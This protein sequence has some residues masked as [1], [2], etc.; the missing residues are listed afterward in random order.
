MKTRVFSQKSLIFYGTL[1]KDDIT[2]INQCRGVVNQLGFAYQLIFI[3]LF[4]LCPKITPFEIVEEL[5]IYAAIQLSSESSEISSYAKNRIK[6]SSHQQNIIKY[7]KLSPFNELARAQLE[8]FIFKKALRLESISLLKTDTIQFL[9]EKKIL[10]PIDETLNRLISTQRKKARHYIFDAVQSKLSADSIAKL[11]ELIST[12]DKYS[13]LDALKDPPAKAS[14]EA[15][16]NLVERLEVIKKTGILSVDISDISSNYQKILA[17]EIRVYS[18]NRIQ[19]LEI[20][21]KNTA[22]VCFLH[23]TYKDLTDYL[24]ETY[25]KLLNTVYKRANLNIS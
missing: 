24:I 4:N 21:R 11:A 25:I 10:S 20:T 12:T 5:L 1:N 6:I 17:K 23:Q 3:R 22:L 7:L 15:I 2:Q 8:N 19:S 16:L 13:K 14:A 18:V 9:K